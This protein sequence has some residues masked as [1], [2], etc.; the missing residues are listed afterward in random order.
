MILNN[1][2][3][4]AQSNLTLDNHSLVTEDQYLYKYLSLMIHFQ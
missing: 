1:K 2:S 4:E 3:F